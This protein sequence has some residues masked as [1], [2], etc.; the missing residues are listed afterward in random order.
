[1]RISILVCIS[2]IS[3]LVGAMTASAQETDH[4]EAAWQSWHAGEISDAHDSALSA[5]SL[6]PADE[7]ARHLIILTSFLIGDY[8][9]S[10]A[11]FELLNPEYE[12]YE[13]LTRVVLDA[14]LH[15][16]RFGE[17]AS[18]AERMSSSENERIWL[19]RRAENPLTVALDSTT[20]IPFAEDNWLGDLMPAIPIELNGKP[21]LGHLDT[22]GDFIA[23]SP[24]MVEELGIEVSP[25][26]TGV[27]NNQPTTI[28]VGLANTLKLGGALLT[29]I[30][31]AS[32][33]ALGGQVEKLIILGTGILSKFLVTW[34]NGE[35][36]MVLTPRGND[37]ARKRHLQTFCE[38]ATEVDF[39]LA[40]DHFMWAHG[41]VGDR[42]VLFF[43]DTGLVTLDGKGRQP[44]IAVSAK[45]LEQW[46]IE[47]G[48]SNFVDSPGPISLGSV[49]VADCS[50]HVFGDRRNLVSFGGLQPGALVS[51]GFLKNF[52]WTV[53]F[54]RH[55]YFLKR[56]D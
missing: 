32:L 31:V 54:D 16:G 41:A 21:Y 56:V 26:G 19:A 37:V 5:L 29:N 50:I 33:T 46:N 2:A 13:T 55:Q 3:L 9:E 15:L 44:A 52:A 1:M 11:Q 34:D 25:I 24:K 48:E 53:D 8:E 22:G 45:T 51:H 17:A 42:E 23:T 30:P 7:R 18:F 36:R 10:I 38:G 47:V 49:S 12:D 6:T 20:V 35:G 39:Y 43:V 14:Y 27:A 40:G 28:S 4:T